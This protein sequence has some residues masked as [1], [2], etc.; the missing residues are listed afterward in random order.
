M[1]LAYWQQNVPDEHKTDAVICFEIIR[2]VMGAEWLQKHF[3]PQQKE[4]GVFKVSF[5]R[6]DEEIAKNFRLVDFCECLINLRFVEG[7]HECI[8]RLKEAK[9]TDA[10][11]AGY[12]ELHI[13]KMLYV[14]EW[15]FRIIK[16]RGKRGDDYD[17]EIICHNQTRCGDTKCKL[18]S[19]GLSSATIKNQL[20]NSRDQLPPNGPGVFFI[21]I[22][23]KWM[24]NPDWQRIAGEGALDFFNSGTQR[25][26]SV[27]FYLE[28]LHFKDGWLA[29]GHQ[30]LEVKNERHN[31]CNFFDWKL[32]HNWRPPAGVPYGMPPSWMRLY[33]FPSELIK[34]GP[35]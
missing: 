29:Q 31:F 14:N 33:N 5:G 3:D 10:A 25:V 23:Q 20:K 17:L 13:A 24:A 9:D 18:K 34:Y 22:P 30:C 15:P 16:P 21:K 26:A 32:L 28:P 19:T 1:L 7:V 6:T 8:A 4:D 11:E 27:V 2:Y 12:A 35:F